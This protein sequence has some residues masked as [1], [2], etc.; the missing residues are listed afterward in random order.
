MLF[1]YFI[2]LTLSALLCEVYGHM[3]SIFSSSK[4]GSVHKIF[5]ASFVLLQKSYV[6]NFMLFFIRENGLLEIGFICD[7][8]EGKSMPV[9]GRGA[10]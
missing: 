6:P 1:T 3:Q 2:V 7:K 8:K 5:V 4:F 9:T 10:P